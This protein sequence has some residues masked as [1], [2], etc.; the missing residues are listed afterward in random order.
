MSRGTQLDEV[1]LLQSMFS[2]DEFEM[3]T[4]QS[5]LEAIQVTLW[6]PSFLSLYLIGALSP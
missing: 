3:K 2:E 6:F 4:S 1:L 5:D